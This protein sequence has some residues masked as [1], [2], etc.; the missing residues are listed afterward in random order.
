MHFG[1]SPLHVDRNSFGLTTFHGG[2]FR[3]DFL[4][5]EIA[6]FDEN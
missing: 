5:N 2:S 4:E 6:G 3:V 1:G